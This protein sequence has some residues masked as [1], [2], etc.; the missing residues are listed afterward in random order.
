MVVDQPEDLQRGYTS[1]TGWLE[2]DHGV[3]LD[4]RA[5]DLD[6]ILPLAGAVRTIESLCDNA[7]QPHFAGR[8]D[9]G[10]WIAVD[11]LPDDRDAPI[12]MDAVVA[13]HL[14]GGEHHPFWPN[15]EI[16]GRGLEQGALSSPILPT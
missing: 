2:A 7:F 5:A 13:Y 10:R 11:L 4:L 15:S 12:L 8:S 16:S 1:A 9:D 14:V 3:M 6:P